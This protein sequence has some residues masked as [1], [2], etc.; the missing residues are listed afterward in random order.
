MIV[1]ELQETPMHFHWNKM[2]DII[3]RGGGNLVIE[4][5][6]S[7]E[8][9]SPGKPWPLGNTEESLILIDMLIM[10]LEEALKISAKKTI[11][12]AANYFKE[13]QVSSLIIT[14]RS[15]DS[16]V[17]SNGTLFKKMAITKFP[18]S[19]MI[20]DE[21]KDKGYL[22]GDTTG[23]GDNFAGGIIA[24]LAW[25]LKSKDI[26]KLD[27]PEA[28]SW[29]TASGGYTCYYGGGTYLKNHSKGKFERVSKYQFEYQKQILSK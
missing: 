6:N 4:L 17:Y 12:E 2:E 25:Q 28:L 20:L 1:E 24:S 9:K 13:Q 21:L 16:I 10:D 8:K 23:C 14:N 15:K 7:D 18:V 5:Y 3:N 29:A 27:L 22:K 19:Q 26:G 11:N